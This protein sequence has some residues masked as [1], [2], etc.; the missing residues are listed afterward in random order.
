VASS[1]GLTWTSDTLKINLAKAD[2]MATAYLSRTTAYY[3]LQSETYAKT[4]AKW[5]DRTSNARSGLSADYRISAGSGGASFE[6]DVYHRVKYGI[7]LE[8]RYNGKYAIINRTVAYEG[9]RFFD[10]ANKVM[11]KMFGGS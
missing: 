7:W 5:T 11:A 4:R 9:P 8:V 2:G 6:I 10:T 3:S 1:V